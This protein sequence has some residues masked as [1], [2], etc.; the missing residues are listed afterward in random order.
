MQTRKC[1]ICGYVHD[2]A[3]D[4]AWE[5]LSDSWVCPLCKAAKSAFALEG[6]SETSKEISHDLLEGEHKELSSLEVSALCSNLAKGC[7]KAS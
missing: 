2:E 3:K 1:T 7:E 4:G 5:N 6:T